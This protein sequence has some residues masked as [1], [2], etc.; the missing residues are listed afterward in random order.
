MTPNPDLHEHDVASDD[1]MPPAPILP[2]PTIPKL[3][4]LIAA[5]ER[6]E[7]FGIPR[8]L[9]TRLNNPGDLIFA[10]QHLAMP[11]PVIGKDGKTRIYAQFP[12]LAD[13]LAALRFQ[14]HLNASRGDS[15]QTFIWHYAPASDGND[16]MSYLASVMRA[17]GETDAQRKL[18]EVIA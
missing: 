15:L 3:D 4:I 10:H 9:P 17:L 14:I 16:P 5:I 12:T 7:G 1:G 13:G 18:A 2:I 6:R 8:T 11:Y